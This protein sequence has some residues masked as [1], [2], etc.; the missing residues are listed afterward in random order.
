MTHANDKA[1]IEAALQQ[2]CFGQ[3]RL[4]PQPSASLHNLTLAR[5]TFG[6]VS[7]GLMMSAEHTCNSGCGEDNI[8]N[9]H[10]TANNTATLC[11]YK[12]VTR[13]W[14]WNYKRLLPSVVAEIQALKRL[15]SHSDII[16]LHAVVAEKESSS[17]IPS[18]TLVMDFATVDLYLVLECQR[19]RRPPTTRTALLTSWNVVTSVA[20]DVQAALQHCHAHGIV[21]G[22]VKPGNLLLDGRTG[23]WQ[24]CDFGIC[25]PLQAD[26]YQNKSDDDEGSKTNQDEN[27]TTK[28]STIP[29]KPTALGTLY[30]RAPEVLLGT[31]AVHSS[32]DLYAAGC[33]VA[34]VINGGRPLFM[35]DNG[36]GGL[37]TS[38]VS[39][40]TCIFAGLGTPATA[41]DLGGLAADWGKLQFTPQPGLTWIQLVPRVGETNTGAPTWLQSWLQALVRINPRQRHWANDKEISYTIDRAAVVQECQ[42]LPPPLVLYPN[43]IGDIVTH[44]H[45]KDKVVPPPWAHLA[46]WAKQRRTFLSTVG[47]QDAKWTQG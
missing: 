47:E 40:L 39:Q 14:D 13:A 8:A 46:A 31:P 18:L 30:Y 9:S 19:R 1:A 22:D 45:N 5:G 36:N 17:S 38:D 24:L 34:E 44:G 20:H 42:I 4:L 26:L 6:D 3:E 35:A 43:K 27:T 16:T 41:E 37:S 23:H 32:V 29:P 33:V 12:T 15:G 7:L 11:A 10:T 2:V 21:H 28:Q 25:Q